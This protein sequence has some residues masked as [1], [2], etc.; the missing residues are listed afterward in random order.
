MVKTHLDGISVDTLTKLCNGNKVMCDLYQMLMILHTSK[1][2][3]CCVFGA[4]R[5][6]KEIGSLLYIICTL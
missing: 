5:G 6:V 1:V 4:V 3:L 2:T